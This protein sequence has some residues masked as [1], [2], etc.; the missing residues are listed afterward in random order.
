MDMYGYDQSLMRA[1]SL[2]WKLHAYIYII[3]IYHY[4]EHV[5]SVGNL[6]SNMNNLQPFPRKI[7]FEFLWEKWIS[8]DL[9]LFI[10]TTTTTKPKYPNSSPIFLMS[11]VRNL[12]EL[13]DATKSSKPL[14]SQ[15]P[16]S[17]SRAWLPWF[18]IDNSDIQSSASCLSKR[19]FS[20][21]LNRNSSDILSTWS[22]CSCILN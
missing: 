21:R 17:S 3:Y 4:Q 20:Q 12:K 1:H 16:A 13:S 15:S 14:H 22:W 11:S 8:V 5:S 9:I 18:L 2:S 10:Y 19:T 7:T 6:N